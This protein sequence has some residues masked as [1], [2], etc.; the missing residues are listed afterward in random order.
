MNKIVKIHGCSGAGKTTLIRA[1]FARAREVGIVR[2][3]VRSDKVIYYQL[4]LGPTPIYVLGDYENNCGG[5]DT[6]DTAEKVMV[7]IDELVPQGHVIHEGLL[8]STYYG[9]MGEHSKQYGDNYIYAF[10][11]TT[12]EE[13]LERV[14]A[15]REA[16]GTTRKFNPDLTRRKHETIAKLKSKLEGW[17]THRILSLDGRSGLAF[18]ELLSALGPEYGK[19]ILQH[20]EGGEASV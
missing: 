2:R 12:L 7:L 13:C 3:F 11:D 10:L 15:R 18:Y 6:I 4:Q 9:A 14:V 1:L 5:C 8:Q 20:G 17:G 16:Q 19:L